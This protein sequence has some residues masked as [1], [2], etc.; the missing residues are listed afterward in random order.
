M[1][2]A[3]VTNDGTVTPE[4]VTSERSVTPKRN[5]AEYIREYRAR[6][7]A[8]N[9][10]LEINDQIEPKLNSEIPEIKSDNSQPNDN[11][12]SEPQLE[13]NK[14]DEQITAE[15]YERRV[16]PDADA[17]AE[18]LRMLQGQ[19]KQSEEINRQQ[20]QRVAYAN[21][22]VEVF[23]WWQANGLKPDDQ[24]FLLANPAVVIPLTNF[25]A[26]EV[27]KEHQV[28]SG[29]FIEAGKRLFFQHV[30]Q[31][32]REQAQANANQPQPSEEPMP[33]IPTAPFLQPMAPSPLPRR[34][35]SSR[36]S[37]VSAPVARET[38]LL[39]D[40][41]DRRQQHTLSAQE[42]EAA[43]ISN[44]TPAEYLRQKLKLQQLR[45][46]GEYGGEPQR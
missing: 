6:K 38:G 3:H 4:S 37:I 25:V 33:A 28:G 16:I 13:P 32:Q 29:E 14:P 31:L 41:F 11:T 45:A 21:Q 30:E 8:N 26:G 10:S 42:V 43:K 20:Q 35:E 44:I 19:L 1:T 27:A 34:Q 24:E 15:Q 36:R 23:R 39:S 12:D 5:R 40:S 18:R 46:S 2:S 7:V 9:P 22:T 17:A